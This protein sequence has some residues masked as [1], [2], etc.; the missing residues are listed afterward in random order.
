MS[1]SNDDLDWICE[2]VLPV[3]FR[4]LVCEAD[5]MRGVKSLMVAVLADGIRCL[6]EDPSKGA[7]ARMRGIAAARWVGSSDSSWP[8]AFEAIC[9]VLSIDAQ[10]LRGRLLPANGPPLD[11]SQVSRRSLR[12]V[13]QVSLKIRLPRKRKRRPKGSQQRAA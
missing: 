4:E 7:H 3:Q 11:G 5:P 8:F 2:T 1:P 12:R 6:T 13:E 9:D 10:A